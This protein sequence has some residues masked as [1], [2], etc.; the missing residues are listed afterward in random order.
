MGT[1]IFLSLGVSLL[2]TLVIEGFVALIWGLRRRDTYYV[3]LLC[4]CLTNPAVVYL[5]R[6]LSQKEPIPDPGQ[7]SQL[8]TLLPYHS[9]LKELHWHFSFLQF[10]R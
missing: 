5:H 9:V 3:L 7:P 6:L 4:N 2:L 10:L 1:E 8:Q